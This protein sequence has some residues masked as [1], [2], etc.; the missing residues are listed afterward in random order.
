M[1][2]P[3]RFTNGVS[4]RA[5]ELGKLDP[6]G[7]RALDGRPVGADVL[8]LG[9]TGAFVIVFAEV[10]VPSGGRVPGRSRV[11]RAARR[12]RALLAQAGVHVKPHM[13]VCPEGHAVFPART[14][15]GVRVIPRA[16]LT[17]EITEHPSVLMPHQVGRA[18]DSVSRE[19]AKLR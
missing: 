15:R 4:A 12:F 17:A 14:A 11:R 1:Q 19:L 5:G 18:A 13:V 6:W 9:T 8:V 7:F 2:Q 16:R 3:A 10:L